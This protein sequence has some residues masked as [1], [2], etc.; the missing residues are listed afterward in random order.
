MAGFI[1]RFSSFA[2]I[3]QCTDLGNVCNVEK[4]LNQVRYF[5]V[6]VLPPFT[7]FVEQSSTLVFGKCSIELCIE[8]NNL[9]P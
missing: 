8:N 7:T 3:L 9:T 4:W 2:L 6:T 5:P 1:W